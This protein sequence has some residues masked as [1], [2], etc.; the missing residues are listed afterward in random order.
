MHGRYSTQLR[1]VLWALLSSAL[2]PAA[3]RLP[4]GPG[5][6]SPSSASAWAVLTRRTI[7][8]GIVPTRMGP[9]R[10]APTRPE[11]MVGGPSQSTTLLHGSVR[12]APQRPNR[13]RPVP[14]LRA[15]RTNRRRHALGSKPS[16]SPMQCKRLPK[17]HT[18]ECV[19]AKNLIQLTKG[20]LYSSHQHPQ[21]EC[22][23]LHGFPS[24]FA[25]SLQLATLQLVVLTSFTICLEQVT[26]VLAN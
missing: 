17:A 22:F 2:L 25:R 8:V 24:H 4:Q 10:V 7:R 1:V 21:L 20:N 3:E 23:D 16:E 26:F 14:L 12:A 6:V 9:I 13:P 18:S 19:H 15:G 5:E 11:I